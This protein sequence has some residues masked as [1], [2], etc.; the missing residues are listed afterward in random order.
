MIINSSGNF[1][2]CPMGLHQAVI[3]D[4]R[5][6]GL[7]P[8]PFKNG[9]LQMKV[10]IWFQ[11]AQKMSTGKPF[12]CSKWF[13]ASLHEKASLRIMIESLLG[14]GLTHDESRS[15][16][17]EKLIGWQCQLLITKNRAGS[18]SPDGTHIENLLPPTNGQNLAVADFIRKKDRQP[19]LEN[20]NQAT[21]KVEAIKDEQAYTVHDDIPF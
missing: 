4:I 13:T 18:K 9:D 7:H 3:C 12:L 20:K 2:A 1:E 14:R 21:A 16:D 11:I 15:F 8:N 5:D 6:E 19:T 10:S 17:L